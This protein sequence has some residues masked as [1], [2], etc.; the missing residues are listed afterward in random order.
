MVYTKQMW[1]LVD[2]YPTALSGKSVT[3]V[4]WRPA[5][6]SS[7]TYCVLMHAASVS[8]MEG[9]LQYDTDGDGMIEN[10]V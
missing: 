7:S 6:I 4:K 8:V 1:F 10:E 5:A 9:C 3:S 2:M